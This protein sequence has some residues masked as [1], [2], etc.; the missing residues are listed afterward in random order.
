MDIYDVKVDKME[1]LKPW[2]D[3]INNIQKYDWNDISY[4][5]LSNNFV[6]EHSSKLRWDTIIERGYVSD[7]LLLEYKE[8]FDRTDWGAFLKREELSAEVIKAGIKHFDIDN[9]LKYHRVPPTVL[10]WLLRTNKIDVS[11][12][13]EYQKLTVKLMEKIV[14][15]DKYYI[16]WYDVVSKQKLSLKFI[17]TFQEHINFR[18]LSRY[19]EMSEEII[20]AFKNKLEWDFISRYQALSK[21]FILKHS[22]KI[23]IS[24]LS[25]NEKVNHKELNERG[26][27]EFLKLTKI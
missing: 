11:E 24:E 13:I 9:L 27:Y 17:Q 7:E 5:K 15:S 2:F 22:D 16:N 18:A 14:E 1:D 8:K 6:K 25:Q 12:I 21:D 10:W 20:E 4:M 26:I 19:Q 3:D 23:N